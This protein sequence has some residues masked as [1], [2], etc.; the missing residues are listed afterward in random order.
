[1]FYSQF[2]LIGLMAISLKMHITY[3]RVSLHIIPD[4]NLK[5]LSPSE[6]EPLGKIKKA[7]VSL[8]NMRLK[9]RLVM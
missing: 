9:L 6:N 2:Y 5:S 3:W 8:K 7:T 1:M 4:V